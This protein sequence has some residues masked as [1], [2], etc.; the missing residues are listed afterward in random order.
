MAGRSELME[1]LGRIPICPEKIRD[2]KREYF[3]RPYEFIDGMKVV[4]TRILSVNT[5]FMVEF[6][7]LA[8]EIY[9][10]LDWNKKGRIVVEYDPQAKK[11]RFITFQEAKDLDIDPDHEEVPGFLYRRK[12]E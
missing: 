11:F 4:P 6:L 5:R 8:R 3:T 9:D 10:G 12:A 2:D 1:S 7:E